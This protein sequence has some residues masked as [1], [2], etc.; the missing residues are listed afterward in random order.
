MFKLLTVLSFP[1][2]R[3]FSVSFILLE[4]IAGKP[5]L[6]TSLSMATPSSIPFQSLEGEAFLSFALCQ[7]WALL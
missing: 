7:P 4:H 1:V 5:S 6:F 2:K 3:V